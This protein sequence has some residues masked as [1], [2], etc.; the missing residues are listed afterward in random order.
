MVD[1][2]LTRVWFNIGQLGSHSRVVVQVGLQL[3]EPGTQDYMVSGRGEGEAGRRGYR[4]TVPANLMIAYRNGL[5]DMVEIITYSKTY[6]RLGI[7][8]V[9][10]YWLNFPSPAQKLCIT[11]SS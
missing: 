10:I 8:F 9:G 3:F 6:S 2:K 4:H 5:H 7:V 1:G 11:L